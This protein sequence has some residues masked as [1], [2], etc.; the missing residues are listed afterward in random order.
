MF[1]GEGSASWGGGPRRGTSVPVRANRCDLGG[2]GSHRGGSKDCRLWVKG[3]GRKLTKK[4]LEEQ[5]RMVI[6]QMNTGLSER[7]NLSE[8]ESLRALAWDGEYSV[9]LVFS[10]PDEHERFY[11]RSGSTGVKGGL[12][13]LVPLDL[14]TLSC[15]GCIR[16]PRLTRG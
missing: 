4:T 3:F 11:G 6:S 5:A 7:D 13:W 9:A 10:D 15:S 1:W 14:R 12:N 8:G 2:Q 16:M